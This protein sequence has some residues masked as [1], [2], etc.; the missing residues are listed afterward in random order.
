MTASFIVNS[1]KTT[2]SFNYVATTAQIQSI[3]GLAS[4]YLWEHGQ[5]NHGTEDK[6]I[7]FASLTNTEKLV[8]VDEHLKRVVVDLANTQKSI[9]AQET[10]RQ[11]EEAS[12]HTL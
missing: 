5:G 10:A 11:A 12:K 2:V 9:K 4:E 8:L 1:T 3:V 7:L 6:P